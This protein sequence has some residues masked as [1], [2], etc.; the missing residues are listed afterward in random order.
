MHKCLLILVIFDEQFVNSLSLNSV[1]P[2]SKIK[3]KG[4]ARSLGIIYSWE[5]L[6]MM[7]LLYMIESLTISSFNLSKDAL[8]KRKCFIMSS[9]SFG[10]ISE[11]VRR[12]TKKTTEWMLGCPFSHP[13]SL[14]ISFPF[15]SYNFR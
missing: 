10:I 1:N 9:L 3:R 13:F 8:F 12:K 5:D 14:S 2:N 11:G 15:H 4:V 6:D 7:N